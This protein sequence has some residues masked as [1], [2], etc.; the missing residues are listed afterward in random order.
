MPWEVIGNVLLE[1]TISE[2]LKGGYKL[3][4]DH[5]QPWITAKLAGAYAER[6]LLLTSPQ[7]CDFYYA[8]TPLS[9]TFGR[10]QYRLPMSL[11]IAPTTDGPATEEKIRIKT[12]TIPF[13]V[14][15]RISIYT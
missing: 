7:L 15:Q 13:T 5:V 4:Q 11:L 9:Y 12:T 8:E 14:P 2:A 6:Y 3:F 10:S 1:A